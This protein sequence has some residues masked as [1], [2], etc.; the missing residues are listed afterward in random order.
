MARSPSG[1][2]KITNLVNHKVYVGQSQN[3][4]ERRAQH[5]EALRNNKHPNAEMQKDWN[6]NNRG[7]RWDV[8]EYCSILQLN[9]REKY[10]IEYLHAM[11]PTGYNL[12]WVPYN[13]KK[14][15]QRIKRK[16][17][18]VKKYHKTS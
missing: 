14:Q 18:A 3:M 15:A 16:K 10:W 2:Y 7:F 13:R 6:E 17:K 11:A 12:D 4:F 9:K 5:F 1:I 8:V